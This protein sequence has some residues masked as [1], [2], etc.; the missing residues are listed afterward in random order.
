MSC[1]QLYLSGLVYW[2]C[3]PRRL[4]IGL[5]LVTIFCLAG[6]ASE[7]N[8]ANLLDR[9]DEA[10]TAVV[11]RAPSTEEHQYWVSRV[12]NGDKKT[13]EALVGAI[14][15]TVSQVSRVPQVAGITIKTATPVKPT[16]KEQLIKDVLTEFIA[17]YKRNPSESEKAWW[18]KRISCGEIKDLGALRKSMQ[19]HKAKGVGKGSA[20]ICG[21]VVTTGS[22]GNSS[23]GV[24]RRSV[25]GISDNPEIRV[26]IFGVPSSKSIE[27]TSDGKFQVREGSQAIATLDEGSVV[28]VSWSGGNYHIRGSGL[29]NDTEE[30]VRLVPLNSAIMQ[31]KTYSDPS[32]TIPGKNYNRFRGIIEIKKCDGCNEL[33]AI[34]QLRTEFYLRGL[35]ETSGEGPENYLLALSIAARTYALYHKVVTGGRNEAKGYDIGS[36]A[37]DQIYRGYEYELITP[38]MAS[39]FNKMRGVI[40]TNGEGDVPIATVYFS[41]SDGRTRSGKEV[42]GTERF[43]YLQ[44]VPDPHH[45]SSRC[46]GHC[47]GMSAQGAYGFAAKDD[48]DFK[49]I[50]TYYYKGVKLVKAY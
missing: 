48:W 17:I 22:S 8:A 13:Y 36:T 24:T 7:A 35:A 44:S 39:I 43:P 2:Q 5:V 15:Y 25:A 21:V 9:V 20:A 23:G 38:R 34:N 26:G 3:M 27:A 45:V 14:G 49:K 1:R 10:F 12:A 29:E 4:G 33:W 28:K 11:G 32:K 41:D 40:V 47:A 6:Q 16:S 37:D 46:L 19:F 30:V 31:I 50:L 18:R 42:W